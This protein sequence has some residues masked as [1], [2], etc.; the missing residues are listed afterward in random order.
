MYLIDW[1]RRFSN[2]IRKQS[3]PTASS[4]LQPSKNNLSPPIYFL[5]FYLPI[6]D[7]VK[8]ICTQKIGGKRQGRE[9]EQA[10]G[11]GWLAGGRE[12]AVSTCSFCSFQLFFPFPFTHILRLR[13]CVFSLSL[14]RFFSFLFGL[15]QMAFVIRF[16]I[17]IFLLLLF[18]V[19]AGRP[20]VVVAAVVVVV[21]VHVAELIVEFE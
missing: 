16:S 10:S 1:G 4:G 6:D 11:C 2:W 18:S 9:A 13:V 8:N 12:R 5:V 21:V 3:R 17:V 7:Q 15:I 20:S 19:V 14:F